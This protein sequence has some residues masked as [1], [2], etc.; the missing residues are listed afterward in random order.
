MRG[1]IH[2]ISIS[3]GGLPKYEIPEA[4]ATPLGIP[5]DVQK[6]TR[7]HGGPARALLIVSLEDIEKLRGEGYPVVAGSLGEN[8]TVS[9]IDFRQLRS[10]QRFNA[11]GALIELTTLRAPC[12]A[13]D[14]FN[15]APGLRIQD[16]LYDAQA[17][18]GDPRSPVWAMG[19]FYAAVVEPGPLL[20]GAT[21]ALA[22]QVV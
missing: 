9:G 13:L 18:A 22:D 15:V 14:M 17:K 7:F 8:L 5:G 10:G 11:S 3:K 1:I 12:S 19:G 6:H 2:Q 20:P 16:R 21:I 4:A